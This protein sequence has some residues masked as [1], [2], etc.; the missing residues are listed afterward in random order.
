MAK[1]ETDVYRILGCCLDCGKNYQQIIPLVD[2]VNSCAGILLA[3]YCCPVCKKHLFVRGIFH[4]GSDAENA[5]KSKYYDF[6]T[7]KLCEEMNDK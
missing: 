1:H 4:I 5:A 2:I 6:K 7:R 3:S